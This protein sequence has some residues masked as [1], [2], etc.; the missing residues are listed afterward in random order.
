M[1]LPG[2]TRR[3]AAGLSISTRTHHPG[4][5]FAKL[6]ISSRAQLDRALPPR[7]GQDQA[8]VGC[9]AVGIP[10]GQ[11]TTGHLDCP[12]AD[13]NTPGR[14]RHLVGRMLRVDTASRDRGSERSTG[15]PPGCQHR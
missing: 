1:R 5:I 11:A 9:R 8:E 4:K 13:A 2:R 15:C 10:V 14:Q 3:S 12:W 7:L 6:G